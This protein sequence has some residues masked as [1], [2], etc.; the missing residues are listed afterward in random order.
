MRQLPLLIPP[1]ADAVT[2]APRTSS[3]ADDEVAV[4][5]DAL[6]DYLSARLGRPVQ[7]TLTRNRST[8]L[9]AEQHPQALRLR[10]HQMFAS[11]SREVREALVAYLGSGSRRAGQV[12]D[13]FI[14]EQSAKI[15]RPVRRLRPQG[16]V[17]DLQAILGELNATYFHHACTANISWG[18][19]SGRRRRRSIQLG[20]YRAGERL[21]TI[22]PSLD[23]G[24]VPRQY[25][26]WVVYHEMLH[27]VFG[28][29]E[30]GG[31]RSLHPPEF[32]VLEQLFPEFE[33]CKEW[34]AKNLSRLLRYRP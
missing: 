31:R 20:L 11:A 15:A 26:A 7:L 29:A 8:M 10:L 34:E 6:G 1:S 17:H 32:A 18:R 23:Q 33:R 3:R 24:F 4:P 16:Q 14:A 21:I 28:V 22:H 2:D 9:S 13:R 19:A 25:V 30:H 27:D 5:T 12:L